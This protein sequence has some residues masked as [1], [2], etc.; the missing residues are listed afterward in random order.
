MPVPAPTR[1][2][3]LAGGR[4]L[5]FDDVGDPE[6]VPVLFLHG[7][8]DSRLA[9][10]PDDDVAR[11][12]G[13]R[14]VAVDRPGSGRSDRRRLG[15]GPGLAEEVGAVAEV[16]GVTSICVMGWSLG[17]LV[18][19]ATAAEAP[20]LVRA[21]GLVAPVPPRE[22][23]RDPRVAAAVDPVRV[24]LAEA[25]CSSGPEDLAQE[26]APYLVPDPLDASVARAHVREAGGAL[27]RAELEA[28]P[29]SVDA[30]CRSLLES[31]Q[32]GRGG[33]HDDVVDQ[34][35]P[36]P[37][38]ARVRCPVV[39]WHGALDVVSPPE[40]GRWLV[41]RLPAARLEVAAGSG[42]RVALTHWDEVLMSVVA[43]GGG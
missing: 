14:L 3:T 12:A 25:A 13:V 28:V 34:F 27:G 16:L 9:R 38:P 11:R 43:A 20:W 32:G 22:A 24:E 1:S 15:S 42:H 33:L 19:L 26:V 5:S 41:D 37:D 30:L 2:V 8:P 29:G 35:G 40:V 4:R 36:G 39:C 7:S 18:A 17:G 10:H 31:V 6:G 21:L 23:Y